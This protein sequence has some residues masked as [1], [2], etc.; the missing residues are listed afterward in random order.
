MT[1]PR[2]S[3]GLGI[4]QIEISKFVFTT[5]NLEWTQLYGVI[6]LNVFICGDVYSFKFHF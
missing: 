4:T 6:S 2:P 1:R 5:S 3:S